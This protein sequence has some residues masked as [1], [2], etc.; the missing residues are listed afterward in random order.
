[1]T[2]TRSLTKY[3]ESLEAIRGGT[4]PVDFAL[5]IIEAWEADVQLAAGEYTITRA[6]EI[7]GKSRGW[8]ARRLEDWAK[9]GLARR[10]DNGT[11]LVSEAAVP[12][13]RTLPSGG[14]D[15][16]LGASEIARRILRAG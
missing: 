12:R 9:R 6:M 2:T 3:R 10:L 15:P 11:W 1:M 4:I 14:F 7:S 5:E 8:F 13:R 16:S